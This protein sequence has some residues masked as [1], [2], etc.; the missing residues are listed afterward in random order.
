MQIRFRLACHAVAIVAA[1]AP[2]AA[3]GSI[4]GMLAGPVAD[5]LPVWAG[6]LSRDAP[7]RPGDPRYLQYQQELE[8]K[9]KHAYAGGKA[10]EKPADAEK[11][12]TA[13]GQKDEQATRVAR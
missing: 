13:D 10:P 7:P 6:G 12:K 5:T 4:N 11:D 3:C 8:E 2:L 1:A 9:R